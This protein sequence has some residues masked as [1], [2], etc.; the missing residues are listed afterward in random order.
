MVLMMAKKTKNYIDKDVLND[1]S[2][3]YQNETISPKEKEQFGESLNLIYENYTNKH[4][5][6]GYDEIIKGDAYTEFIDLTY[7]YFIK[8]FK[9]D[10]NAFSYL[11]TMC[12]NAWILTINKYHKAKENSLLWNGIQYFDITDDQKYKE[13]TKKYVFMKDE[14]EIDYE[15]G[16]ID[17]KYFEEEPKEDTPEQVKRKSIRNGFFK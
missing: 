4:K 5:F 16:K 12:H 15:Y 8:N 13:Y 2:L 7:R 14:E 11:T 9:E 17:K 10:G 1:L 6:R 3:K